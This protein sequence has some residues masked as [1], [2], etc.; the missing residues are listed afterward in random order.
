[1][2]THIV[3]WALIPLLDSKHNPWPTAAF[4]A[5]LGSKNE[6]HVNTSDG[7]HITFG[8]SRTCFWCLTGILDTFHVIQKIMFFFLWFWPKGDFCYFDLVQGCLQQKGFW[9][10]F[11]LNSHLKNA[12]QKFTPKSPIFGVTQ[13]NLCM[14][15]LKFFFLI[16]ILKYIYIDFLDELGED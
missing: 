9:V 13:Q 14:W 15:T 10:F 8:D 6:L 3:D 11:T 12:L 5:H 7:L 1:M 16:Y 4:G 2:L